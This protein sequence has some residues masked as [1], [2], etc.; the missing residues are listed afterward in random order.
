MHAWLVI[1]VCLT[2]DGQA[3]DLLIK[4]LSGLVCW[5]LCMCLC[6]ILCLHLLDSAS[7]DLLMRLYLRWFPLLLLLPW[8]EQAI[9][10]YH[11]FVF[12]GIGRLRTET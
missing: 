2:A 6:S 4:M 11:T 7:T 5:W 8:S 3:F 10:S 9:F 12:C 1:F